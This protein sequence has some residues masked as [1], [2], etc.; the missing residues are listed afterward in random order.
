MEPFG[1]F[2]IGALILAF[3]LF[4]SGHG[5]AMIIGLAIIADLGLLGLLMS[6][7]WPLLLVVGIPIALLNYAAFFHSEKKR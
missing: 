6:G 3:V 5:R 4:Y 7:G 1:I 2:V